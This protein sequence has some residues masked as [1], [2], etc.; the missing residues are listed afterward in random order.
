[1]I[2]ASTTANAAVSLGTKIGEVA[3]VAAGETLTGAAGVAGDVCP[4]AGLVVSP[5]IMAKQTHDIGKLRE[6]KTKDR[7]EIEVIDAAL[8]EMHN[9]A[10]GAEEEIKKEKAKLNAAK[11]QRLARVQLNQCK[12]KSSKINRALT[13]TLWTVGIGLTITGAVGVE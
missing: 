1:M 10:E 9:I 13:A 11:Q 4:I 8:N 5:L 2:F 12:I 3:A 7:A 6:A